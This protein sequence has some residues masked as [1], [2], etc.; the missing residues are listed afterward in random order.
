MNKTREQLE[1]ELNDVLLDYKVAIALERPV[2]IKEAI[3]QFAAWIKANKTQ[4]RAL[5]PKS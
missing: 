3:E 1:R 5:C 4:L 2:W